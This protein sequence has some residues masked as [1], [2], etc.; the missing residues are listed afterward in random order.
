VADRIDQAAK[1]GGDSPGED[2]ERVALQP[3]D[4]RSWHPSHSLRACT[5]R[6]PSSHADEPGGADEIKF[7]GLP[8]SESEFALKADGVSADPVMARD[9][10]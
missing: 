10:A 4:R 6:Q 9:R 8:S 5:R 1:T 2:A 3:N 7:V